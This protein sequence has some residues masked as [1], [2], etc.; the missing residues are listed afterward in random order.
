MGRGKTG[1]TSSSIGLDFA[2][3]HLVYESPDKITFT[4]LRKAE[5][6][7]IDLALVAMAGVVLAL[8]YIELGRDIRVISFRRA[9]RKERSVYEQVIAN[10]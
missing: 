2:D 3:A 5:E 7:Q 8:I 4:S 9:S 10:D 1:R 6:R